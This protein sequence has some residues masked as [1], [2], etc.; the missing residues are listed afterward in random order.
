[1][2]EIILSS[3]T[4]EEFR[5]KLQNASAETGNHTGELAI[6]IDG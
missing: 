2:K 4:R 3:K 5:E 6:V 1:M